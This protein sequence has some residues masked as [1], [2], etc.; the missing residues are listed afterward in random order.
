MRGIV[1]HGAPTLR[2]DKKQGATL[3]EEFNDQTV[4]LPGFILPTE[5]DGTSVISFL[6]VPY[7]GACI[8]VP[9]P[10]PNQMVYVNFERG[11]D[12]GRLF[13]A[14]QVTGKITAGLSRTPVAPVGYTMSAEK[15]D[16]FKY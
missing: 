10:P 3:T 5:F 2:Y 15:V 4:R 1:G 9:P 7:F 12:Q 16:L 13:S 14:V 8:H 11:F 6:L